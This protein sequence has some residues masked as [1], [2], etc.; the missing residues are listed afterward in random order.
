MYHRDYQVCKDTKWEH[1]CHYNK[2]IA[3][4]K[5]VNC[6]P[7]NSSYFEKRTGSSISKNF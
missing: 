1:Q 7:K 3:N 4:M 5:K 6:W 2:N